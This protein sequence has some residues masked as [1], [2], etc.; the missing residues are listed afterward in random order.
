M[1]GGRNFLEVLF[2]AGVLE[3]ELGLDLIELLPALPDSI[4]PVPLPLGKM[5]LLLDLPLD[6]PLALQLP[7][8]LQLLE[9]EL[10]PAEL[11]ARHLA[12]PVPGL[13]PAER[14]GLGRQGLALE[15]VDGRLGALVEVG[16]HWALDE[17]L[18]GA[19]GGERLV[20]GGRVE[21]PRLV[22]PEGFVPAGGAG[23]LPGVV[24]S[25]KDG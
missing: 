7:L 18:G 17:V 22:L 21:G 12:V 6:E 13:E 15:A 20:V 23:L 14:Q 24:L 3:V 16:A 4:L 19:V 1:D 11:L 10:S 8:Y 2:F 25:D 9:L 5:V